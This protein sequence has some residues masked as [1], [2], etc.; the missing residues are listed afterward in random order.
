VKNHPKAYGDLH[1]SHVE[2]AKR[3]IAE[4]KRKLEKKGSN[5]TMQW[6]GASRLAQLQF[7]SPWRL[8]PTTDGGR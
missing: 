4:L 7:G 3:Y 2:Q 8:A 1:S 6:M 5:H